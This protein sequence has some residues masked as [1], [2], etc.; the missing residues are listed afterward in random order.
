MSIERDSEIAD[1]RNK[2]IGAKQQLLPLVNRKYMKTQSFRLVVD[3]TLISDEDV[4][5]LIEEVIIDDDDYDATDFYYNKSVLHG[6]KEIV[7]YDIAINNREAVDKDGEE[8]HK[9]LFELEKRLREKKTTTTI[10]PEVEEWF[11]KA[12]NRLNDKDFTNLQLFAQK[13]VAEEDV[14]LD[15]LL[16]KYEDISKNICKN[17]R[18][19]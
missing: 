18:K 4:D 7:S 12:G 6:K 11:V 1:I 5:T 3:S 8:N 10:D 14:T 16:K 2:L 9:E 15:L 17:W 19:K 13:C